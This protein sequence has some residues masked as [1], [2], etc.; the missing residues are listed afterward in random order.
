M[1]KKKI[2]IVDY[3]FV[4]L[5]FIWIHMSHGG[6]AYDVDGFLRNVNCWDPHVR[7]K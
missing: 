5:V 2:D 4:F 6:L 1:E 3:I 7:T